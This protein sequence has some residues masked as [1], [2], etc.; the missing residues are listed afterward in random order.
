MIWKISFVLIGLITFASC[1]DESAFL[2]GKKTYSPRNH[3]LGI[4]GGK[5]QR[6]QPLQELLDA[7]NS[8]NPIIQSLKQKPR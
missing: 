6:E 8:I 5:D 7:T 4:G 3:G 2:V 1:Q